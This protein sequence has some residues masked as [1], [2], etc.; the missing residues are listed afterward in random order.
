[1]EWFHYFQVR[2][3]LCP[4]VLAYNSNTSSMLRHLRAKHEHDVASASTAPP[5]HANASSSYGS[6]LGLLFYLCQ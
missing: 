1:M 6:R 5:N 3:L 2:C 4:Q